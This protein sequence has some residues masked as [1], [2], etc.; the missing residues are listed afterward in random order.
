M[1]LIGRSIVA[2]GVSISARPLNY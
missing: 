1:P 2:I